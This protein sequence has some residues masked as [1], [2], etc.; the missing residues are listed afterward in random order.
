[1]EEAPSGEALLNWQQQVDEVQALEA[2]YGDSFRVLEA[3]GVWHIDGEAGSASKGPCASS[4]AERGGAAARL[5]AGSL[6][7][8]DA[9]CRAAWALHCSLLVPVEPPAG[10]LRLL[11]P[12]SPQQQRR[13]AGDATPRSSSSGGGGSGDAGPGAA[14]AAGAV[15][16]LPPICLQLR[17]GEGY[18]SERAPCVTL[19]ALWLGPRQAAELQRQLAR[20]WQEQGPGAPFCYTW[21]DWLQSSALE[22][23]GAAEELLLA[24]DAETEPSGSGSGAAA[25]SSQRQQRGEQLPADW[26]GGQ[27][28]GRS[29]ES[30]EADESDGGEEEDSAE[31]RLVKLLR[32]DA[33]QEHAA[34]AAALH[35][36]GV[37]LEERPGTA[38]V[39]LEGCRH[40]W[41]ADCLGQQA[42]L[43]VAEGG[44]DQ[45]R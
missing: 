33:V 12:E 38:F 45:L 43:H 9:P 42:R 11:L 40:A 7:A 19:S 3:S 26:A 24:D 32:Y 21:A 28:G 23:L 8:V 39:R 15:R 30:A 20:L 10:S 37:C 6:A 34:F 5:D 44:L 1:M 14:A 4:G 36:C 27:P 35:T 18:P 31:A 22:H 13:A 41:C 16:H 29:E 25:A 2:I 17:L